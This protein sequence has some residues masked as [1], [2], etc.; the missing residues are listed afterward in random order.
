MQYIGYLL[1][2]IHLFLLGWSIGGFSEMIFSNV[3]WTPFTN[4]DLPKWWL[5]IHWGSVLI[6][7]TGF[8]YG[9][10]T[11]WSKT[12]QFMTFGYLMLALVCA[13]ETLGFLTN[14]SKYLFM[15]TEYLVYVVILFLLFK[16][17]YFIN[18]FR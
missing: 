13:V 15:T 7:S 12:P 4:R 8:L 6:A 3:P 10:F 17:S 5:P 18:F 9:Y 1:V 11:Q 16:S 14:K 2:L